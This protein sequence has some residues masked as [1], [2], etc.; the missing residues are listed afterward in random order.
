MFTICVPWRASW[1]FYMTV[2]TRSLKCK[3]TWAYPTSEQKNTRNADKGY[4]NYESRTRKV[5][6]IPGGFSTKNI[7][8]DDFTCHGSVSKIQTQDVC[9]TITFVFDV[10]VQ[11][12]ITDFYNKWYFNE[13]F[14]FL[15]LS[16]FFYLGQSWYIYILSKQSKVAHNLFLIL[17]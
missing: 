16:L 8:Y 2:I 1:N 17:L 11:A 12:F 14:Y 6:H 15:V 10:N 7:P 3:S 9:K 4:V 13:I 5:I